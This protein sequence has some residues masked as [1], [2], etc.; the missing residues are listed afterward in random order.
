MCWSGTS[1]L[2]GFSFT[3]DSSLTLGMLPKV[4]STSVFSSLQWDSVL[5]LWYI[6]V[7]LYPEM[8][9]IVPS[10]EKAHP[11]AYSA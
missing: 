6:N 11:A 10:P 1:E 3:G 4:S 9:G 5:A 7:L 8:S 2:Y